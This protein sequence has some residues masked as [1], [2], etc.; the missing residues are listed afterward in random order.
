MGDLSL[1]IAGVEI[2]DKV[3]ENSIKISDNL[4]QRKTCQFTITDP[5]NDYRPDEGDRV[6]ITFDGDIEYGGTI[7]TI[8]ASIISFTPPCAQINITVVDFTQ[9][10]DRH[11]V[12]DVFEAPG[13]VAGDIVNAFLSEYLAVEGVTA[14][15]IE[16]GPTVAKITYN[17]MMLSTAMNELAAQ[18]GMVWYI[19]ANLKLNFHA[20]D[21]VP[22][23]LDLTDN[24]A[25]FRN[26]KV[27]KSRSAYLNRQYV[28]GGVG[29]TESRTESFVGDSLRKTFSLAF[30]VALV[31]TSITVNTVPKTIG[32]RGVDT[33][34]DWYWNVND[35]TI[36]QD[37]NAA[38]LLLTD[39][40]AITYIGLFP[41]L[42]VGENLGEITARAAVEGGSGVYEAVESDPT[43][44]TIDLAT[45]R[46]DGLLARYAQMMPMASYEIDYIG[47]ASGQVQNIDLTD[48]K[49]DDAFLITSM[50][51]QYLNSPGIWRT[52]IKCTSGQ[53]LGSWVEFFRS[54]FADNG[55]LSIRENEQVNK[56]QSEDENLALTDS[57]GLLYPGPV[58]V[59]YLIVAGAGGGGS[60]QGG[61]GGGGGVQVGTIP[62]M[63][64]G[65]HSIT[66]GDGGL[67]GLH[68]SGPGLHGDIGGD[69]FLYGITAKGG[70]GGGGNASAAQNGGSGGGAGCG[71]AVP[72]TGT[73]GQGND[74]GKAFLAPPQDGGG[75]GGAIAA[76]QAPVGLGFG[77]KGGDGYQWVDG[78]TYGGG[79]GGGG[80]NTPGQ[81]G[82]GGLGGG[83][84]GGS[85]TN[86]SDAAANTGGGGG[87]GGQVVATI[88]DGGKGGS[89]IVIVRYLTASVTADGTGGTITHVGPYT[90]HTFLANDTF[91][92]P[93]Q[94]LAGGGSPLDDGSNDPYTTARVS[95]RGDDPNLESGVDKGVVG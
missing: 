44:D 7:E 23:P 53:F 21:S 6:F 10:A 35:N 38:P 4:G 64:A 72:G 50:V 12:T 41:L 62:N 63:V 15:L 18:T 61:G 71:S 33:G 56:L 8:E 26:F 43:I 57:V 67:G 22:A 36:T 74:G 9:L 39:T 89:G 94:G 5:S 47:L 1:T 82:L 28:V 49:V 25:I 31:P 75:G 87:G 69:S 73:L 65:P 17:Y 54:L 40:L 90:Y 42:V 66:V 32:I 14:G 29:Q 2:S 46:V 76:G 3:A 85:T 58:V 88:Y 91:N 68:P 48:E 55:G 92:S 27:Q 34:F 24:L 37:D 20:Q 78:N 70:G 52:Q 80:D 59:D 93:V 51:T 77:G 83:A 84:T 81:G 13:Q 86:G 45:Q 79:G 19:D 95:T 11:L 60:Q 16:S 30:P